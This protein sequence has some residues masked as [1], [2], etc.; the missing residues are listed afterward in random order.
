MALN[1]I[2]I[3]DT[4]TVNTGVVYDITKATGQSY[5]SLSAA[6]GT[7]GNNVPSE[8]R[9]GG[10]SIRFVSNSD[11][12]YVQYR[13]L[14]NEFTAD[15]TQWNIYSESV[16]VENPEY[17]YVKTDREGKI[18]WAIKIDGSIYYGAGVPQQ[19]IDYIEEKLAK[20]SLDE[21][22]D[23]VA[24]LTDYLG[25]D[26]TLKILIDSKLDAEGLDSDALKTVQTVETTEYTEVK[27]D[28][29]SKILAGRTLDGVA[30]E[31]VGFET[32]KVSIGGYIIENT[33]DPEG[34]TEITTDA[35]G[36]LI[37][38]RGK[39][40]IK[41]ESCGLE[42]PLLKSDEIH[43][44]NIEG[45]QRINGKSLSDMVGSN[46][47]AASR[48]YDLPKYGKVDIQKELSFTDGE[49]SYNPNK[50]SKVDGKYYVTATLMDG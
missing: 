28:S 41:V 21:Y 17:V 47:Y 9:E 6:L 22:E 42:T 16:Y 40:G 29:E 25:S 8:V 14:T 24:F 23:I 5:D 27:T 3:N 2:S 10:M 43:T 1:K 30:F 35:A 11:N 39:D 49:T 7:D 18:L 48:E 37:S 31:N 13:L 12:K 45:L 44:P 19:V 34:R 26:T 36:R 33:D 15:T 50:I 38:Y 46:K 4:T 32:P 20:L